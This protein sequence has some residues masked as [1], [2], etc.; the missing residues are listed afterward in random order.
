MSKTK[1]LN[2]QTSEITTKNNRINKKVVNLSKEGKKVSIKEVRKIY[3]YLIKE[4]K[5]NEEDIYIQVMAHRELTLKSLGQGD[6][7]DWEDDEYYENKVSWSGPRIDQIEYARIV[8]MS[9]RN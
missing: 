3:D 8:I 5:V 1:K 9:S 6:F 4:K 7:K 2:V